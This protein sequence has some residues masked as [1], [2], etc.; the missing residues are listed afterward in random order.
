[1]P[2]LDEVFKKSGLPT[3]TFVHPAEF[4]RVLAAIRTPGRGIIV[5]GPS[6]IGKTS[7]VKKV[8]DM[9]E[10][11]DSCLWLSAR[12]PFDAKV[13]AS[14]PK[15]PDVGIVVIDDFHRLPDETKRSLTDHIK[16]L[17][18]E[19]K[20]SSK[21]IL[22]GINRAS[23]SLVEYAP[24]LLHRVETIRVGRTSDEHLRTLISLG[25]VAL[26]CTFSLAEDIAKEAGG[27]RSSFE[28]R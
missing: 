2:R 24:D 21:I 9:L 16:L 28:S 25:E 3:H 27:S 11:T 7:C 14:I 8:L 13:I 15:E 22:I 12:K 26:N 1:M 10:L 20:T 5:E 4:D 6:G 23:Q 18:D 17:A 19:E